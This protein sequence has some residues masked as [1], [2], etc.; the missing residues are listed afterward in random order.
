VQFVDRSPVRRSRREPLRDDHRDIVVQTEHVA[1]EK[2]VVQRAER[3]AVVQGVGTVQL[4]PPDMSRLQPHR[5][6]AGHAVEAAE[7]ALAVP[8]LQDGG[9]PYGTPAAVRRDLRR[10][11][12]V[13]LDEFGVE[14]DGDQDVGLADILS[15]WSGCRMCSASTWLTQLRPSCVRTMSA[16]SLP[17]IRGRLRIR[18]SD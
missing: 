7:R 9:G 17:G 14:A 1:F 10:T 3:Q 16:S 2:L 6:T 12:C 15:T 8:G 18:S 5:H 11:S 4:E 13:G